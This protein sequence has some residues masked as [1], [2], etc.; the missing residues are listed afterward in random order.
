MDYRGCRGADG[1]YHYV[2]EFFAVNIIEFELVVFCL[3]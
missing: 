1:I 3:K 2:A